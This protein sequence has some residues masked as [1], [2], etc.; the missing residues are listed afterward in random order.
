MTVLE[1]PK[2][3]HGDW[4]VL[5]FSLIIYLWPFNFPLLSRISYNPFFK[6]PLCLHPFIVS[7][8]HQFQN[9]H[10]TLLHTVLTLEKTP[11]DKIEIISKHIIFY[12]LK[13]VKLDLCCN[14]L[15]SRDFTMLIGIE[16]RKTEFIL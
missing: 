16:Q 3:W 5:P 14:F 6:V 13:T 9:S 2:N 8:L 11:Q 12:Q 7:S 15:C 1:G 4:L 10:I